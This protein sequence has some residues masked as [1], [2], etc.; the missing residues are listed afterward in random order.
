MNGAEELHRS[1]AIWE[2]SKENIQPLK[3]GRSL[4]AVPFELLIDDH[5]SV[6]LQQEKL[7]QS[8][9]TPLSPIDPLESWYQRIRMAEQLILTGKTS[10]L[11][12]LVEECIESLQD[13]S[14]YWNDRR[15][16]YIWQKLSHGICTQLADFYIE[17]A[18]ELESTDDFRQANEVLLR[19][20]EENAQ[21]IEKLKSAHIEFLTRAGVPS[22][23]CDGDTEIQRKFSTELTGYGLH[24]TVPYLR[25]ADGS[26]YKKLC[27]ANKKPTSFCVFSADSPRGNSFP[28]NQRALSESAVLNEINVKENV[29]TPLGGSSFNRKYFPVASI[30]HSRAVIIII[31]HDRFSFQVAEVDASVLPIFPIHCQSLTLGRRQL[32]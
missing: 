7:S 12:S 3:C 23:Q 26:V 10:S 5:R 27:F 31:F 20:I 15:M 8:E 9:C 22:H 11:R 18:S 14:E 30:I 4:K 1:P 21:P 13:R 28:S 32:V 16:L 2:L 29:R 6:A 25:P 24:K 19:G 17:W